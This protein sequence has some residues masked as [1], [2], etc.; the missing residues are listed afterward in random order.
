MINCKNCKYYSKEFDEF[1]Q[2]FDDVIVVGQENREKHYCIFYNDHIPSEIWG[3]KENC[4]Y[5]E[6]K[7]Q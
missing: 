6:Q 4:P 5:F 3:N 1:R 2:Q 7:S